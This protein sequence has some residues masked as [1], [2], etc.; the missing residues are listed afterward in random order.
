MLIAGKN[1]AVLWSANIWQGP[2]QSMPLVSRPY[3]P[4]RRAGAML[5]VKA[6]TAAME[7]PSLVVAG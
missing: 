7:Q 3:W 1:D 2:T 4:R 5:K 6:L